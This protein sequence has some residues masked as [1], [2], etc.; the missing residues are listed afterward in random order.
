MS[1][2]ERL[3]GAFTPDAEPDIESEENACPRCQS[4]RLIEVPTDEDFRTAILC[5]DCG[6]HSDGNVR[7]T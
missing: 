6:W 2:W 3:K 1:F 5:G 4:T 7:G